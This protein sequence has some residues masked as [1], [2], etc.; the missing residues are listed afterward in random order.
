[1]TPE[2]EQ[3]VGQI[4]LLEEQLEHRLEEARREFRYTLEGRRVLFSRE[5]KLLHRRYRTRLRHYIRHAN[6]WSL[7]TAP[8]IY[9]M[10][11]PLAVL[12]LS[13]TLYQH[14]CFRAY[15]IPRVRRRDYMVIDRH[16]L[17]YLNAVEKINCA[18]CGYGNGLI[19][20]S[21]EIVART[22]QYWCP[23][24][25]ARRI[26]DAHERY[27]RFFHY[28]DAEAYSRSLARMKKEYER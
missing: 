10:V 6:P 21:R 23:I 17:D 12:D 25:H 11:I 15:G 28:G 2:I 16:R 14:I 9:G 22:E 7:V 8:V 18:Y 4:R 24:R 26:P 19:A 13:L 5:V 27:K 3:I 20:Y 1:M